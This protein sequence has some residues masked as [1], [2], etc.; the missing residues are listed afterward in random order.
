MKPEIRTYEEY[1]N[2]I[3]PWY[4]IAFNYPYYEMWEHI[5]DSGLDMER[6]KMNVQQDY[7][8][9]RDEVALYVFDFEGNTVFK[10]YH[11]TKERAL[12]YADVLDY[13]GD[14]NEV[15]KIVMDY[16]YYKDWCKAALNKYEKRFFRMSRHAYLF[17]CELVELLQD[18]DVFA[19]KKMIHD[20]E[21]RTR[22]TEF[23]FEE[24]LTFRR[25]I[26][27]GSPCYPGVVVNTI[28]YEERIK[29]YKD[30]YDTIMKVKGLRRKAAA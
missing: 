15:R 27:R 9:G 22:D 7:H 16:H 29:L 18:M 23:Y 28:P 25:V 3:N 5:Q 12:A 24:D 13:L 4:A 10:A 20:N 19:W 2:H 1:V 8:S 14:V 30:D 11:R 21:I 26:Y 6:S 17:I